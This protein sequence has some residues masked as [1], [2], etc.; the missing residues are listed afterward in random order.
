MT[1]SRHRIHGNPFNLHGEVEI[2]D[3]NVV[4]GRAAP[5]ALDIGFGA[6][7]FTLE[8][9]RRHPEFN[10]IGVEIRTHL[11][12]D[13]N[14]AAR[15]QKL[16]N[17]HAVLANAN[18]H[19][20]ELVPDNSVVLTTINFPDPWYKKRHHKRRVVQPEWLETL[21]GKLQTEAT[22]HIATDYEPGALHAR[23]VFDSSP[24]FRNLDGNG[25]W[26]PES[27][28]GIATERERTHLARNEPIYRLRY[29][30]CDLP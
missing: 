15:K 21:A 9:A 27:T 22:V 28:T 1:R 3:W 23:E 5:F 6:G 17:L 19:L 24:L 12:D 30:R 16:T 13:L 14:D 11:V 26:A 10:V 29:R 4:F 18:L 8:L 25:C 20:K 7:A 2:P